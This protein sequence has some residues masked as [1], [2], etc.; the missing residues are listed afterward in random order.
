MLMQVYESE[1]V[2]KNS[3]YVW[4]KHFRDV[5]ETVH[6]ESRSDRLLTST[7]PVNIERRVQQYFVCFHTLLKRNKLM[8]NQKQCSFP[9]SRLDF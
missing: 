5:K 9:I 4:F 3:V 6:D 7:T 2:G 8:L 1:A